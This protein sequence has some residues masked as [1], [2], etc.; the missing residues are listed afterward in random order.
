MDII[1][2]VAILSGLGLFFGVGLAYASR[3]FEVKE[4]ERVGKVREQLPGANCGAC[5]YSGCDGLAEAIVKDG[6]PTNKCPVGGPKAASAISQIMG[7]EEG[8]VSQ[9]V[10]RVICQGT[11]KN[12]DMKYDYEGIDDCH[13]ANALAGGM[14]QCFYG[15]IGLGSCK[16]VCP[17]DAIEVCDGLARIDHEK[18]T[19][20]GKCVA[21]C[22]KGIIKMVPVLTGFTVMCANKEKGGVARKNCKV[23]CIACMKCQKACPSGAI[24]IENNLARID[25]AKCTNC[26]ECEKV[27]PQSTIVDVMHKRFPAEN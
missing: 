8:E 23:A 9:M 5:G 2:P 18:C 27:C 11:W 19:G 20:C 3:I 15:C 1:I 7:V 12:A 22:P 13:A 25:P 14:S 21:E 10:A 24:T 17:F 26:G 6:V 16:R 4:D